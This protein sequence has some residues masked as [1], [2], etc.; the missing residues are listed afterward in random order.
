MGDVTLRELYMGSETKSVTRVWPLSSRELQWESQSNMLSVG[1]S[2][3]ERS[4]T[5]GL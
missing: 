3:E 2:C 4:G 1:L 5:S